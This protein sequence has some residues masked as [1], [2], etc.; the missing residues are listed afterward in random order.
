MT[1]TASPTSTRP[2]G[3]LRSAAQGLGLFSSALGVAEL[4]APRTLARMTG[5]Q[6]R[7]TLIRACGLR[8][9]VNGVGL[10][11]SADP[12][13]WLWGRIA[14]DALDLSMLAVRARQ[15]S[16]R[17]PTATPRCG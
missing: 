7:E 12:R 16:H 11:A 5:M 15:P 9:I 6:G 4:P 8:E 10:L 2:A 3:A 17:L 14:G 13:P 1:R